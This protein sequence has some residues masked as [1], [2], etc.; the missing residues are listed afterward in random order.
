[1]GLRLP[2]LSVLAGG[3]TIQEFPLQTNANGI[4]EIAMP[5]PNRWAVAVSSNQAGNNYITTQP[6]LGRKYG[7]QL[8]ANQVLL[9]K[10]SDYGGFVQAQLYYITDSPLHQIGVTLIGINPSGG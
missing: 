10:Y 5:D 4:V 9:L 8:P 6:E 7:I 1:M 2:N 3:W